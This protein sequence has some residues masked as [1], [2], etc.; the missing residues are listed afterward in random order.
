MRSQLC[1]LRI[2]VTAS[3]RNYLCPVSLSRNEAPELR[4]SALRVFGRLLPIKEQAASDVAVAF[5]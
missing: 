3:N 2:F 5:A 4:V 1:R